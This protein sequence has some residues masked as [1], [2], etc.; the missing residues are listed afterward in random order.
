MLFVLEIDDYWA[1]WMKDM[2]FSI[3]IVWLDAEGRVLSVVEGAA[4]ES[5]PKIFLPKAAAHYVLELPAGA[6]A[7]YGLAEG[8]KV[9]VE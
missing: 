5:Y 4:P 1:V 9:V 7:R 6:A 3:D 2:G 8:A